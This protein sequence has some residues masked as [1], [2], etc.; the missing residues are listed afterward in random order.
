MRLR[1]HDCPAGHTEVSS[2]PDSREST[3][4]ALPLRL[5]MRPSLALLLLLVLVCCSDRPVDRSSS[6]AAEADRG[7]GAREDR[8]PCVDD[9]QEVDPGARYRTAGCRD[10]GFDLHVVELDPEH[11]AIDVQTGER[12]P[13]SAAVDSGGARFA[14]NASFFGEDDRPLGVLVSSG[15]ALQKAHPVSWQSVFSISR[16]GRARIVTREEWPRIEDDAFA[17]AQAG[18]RLIIA[19][20]K[21]RVK[22]AEPSLRS[23]VC[24][25]RE[26]A[27]RFF[28]TAAGRLLDVHEMVEL[29]ARSEADGGMGCH[30]AML[31]DGGPSAQMFLDTTGRKIDT[32]GDVV[33]VFIV[34]RPRQ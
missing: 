8:S 33:P 16:D 17:A 31:F 22:R 15:R 32:G 21:N 30:D 2:F 3:A 19:G 25:T 29:A 28:V 23:G 12:R 6:S 1:P 4:P 26:G 10:G 9:W 24:L 34:A 13:M 20:E 7:G 14:V 18:P 5:W 11:W 27:I